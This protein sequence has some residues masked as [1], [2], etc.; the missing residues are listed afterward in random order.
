M[1]QIIHNARTESTPFFVTIDH[2]SVIAKAEKTL[3][4]KMGTWLY[5]SIETARGCFKTK[6]SQNGLFC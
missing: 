4:R 2:D 3:E 1:I 5:Q 6:D